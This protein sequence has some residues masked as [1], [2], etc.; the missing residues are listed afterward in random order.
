MKR[1]PL[2]FLL[3]GLL[4]FSGAANAFDVDFSRDDVDTLFEAGREALPE[5]VDGLVRLPSRL[6]TRALP[7]VGGKKYKLEIAAE[8]SG[9]FVVETNDRAHVLTLQS[10][11]N[12][13][14]STYEV[15]FQN[16][17]GDDIRGL[18]GVTPGGRAWLGGFFLTNQRQPYVAVFYAPPDAASLKVRFQSNSRTTHIASLHLVEETEEKTVNPNPDFRYGELNY[19]GWRPAR[20]GRIYTRPD[21]KRVLHLGYGGVSPIFPLSPE[22][23]Y[24][25]SATGEGKPL[26]IEYFD[27]DGKPLLQRFLIRLSSKGEETDMVPPAGTVMARVSA[28][29]AIIEEFKVVQV[30]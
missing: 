4:G 12:Q 24:R 19:A 25:I 23:T 10:P 30:K 17:A 26:N 27:K 28:L 3:V 9:D 7:V 14:S 22:R 8:T 5:R 1:M 6:S 18:E 11:G 13:L 21:G 20:D 16:A 15:S 2:I 29:G